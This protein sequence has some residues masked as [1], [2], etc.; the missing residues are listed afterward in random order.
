MADIR[1]M[2]HVTCPAFRNLACRK[3]ATCSP[4]APSGHGCALVAPHLAH[5]GANGVLSGLQ[6]RAHVFLG[7]SN[8]P[9]LSST[10]WSFS[11]ALSRT[12]S[13]LSSAYARSSSP[14]TIRRD[15]SERAHDEIY[16]RSPPVRVGCLV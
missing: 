14:R 11:T 5:S 10:V 16:H 12:V 2:S 6:R 3:K 4:F 9:C 15:L 7:L 8:H 13:G 1:Y